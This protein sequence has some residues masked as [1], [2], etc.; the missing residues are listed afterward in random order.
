MATVKGHM[1]KKLDGNEGREYITGE[2]AAKLMG[3]HPRT[4]YRKIEKGEIVATHGKRNRLRIALDD[5]KAWIAKNQP[6]TDPL[7]QVEELSQKLQMLEAQVG[8]LLSLK[9]LIHSIQQRLDVYEQVMTISSH[10]TGGMDQTEHGE[11]L[12]PPLNLHEVI[13]LLTTAH[14]QHSSARSF[15]VLEKRGL[16]IGTLTVAEFARL[17]QVQ[18]HSIKKLFKDRLISLAIIQ[19]ENFIRN[20]HEWWITPEQQ[21]TLIQYWQENQITYVACSTCAHENSV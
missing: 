20:G 18:V 10:T 16:P 8:E 7:E 17:H 13:R 15:S 1:L 14:S 5:V 12:P 19:R 6:E 3:V 11:Q 9:A 4:V 2:Q 21:A